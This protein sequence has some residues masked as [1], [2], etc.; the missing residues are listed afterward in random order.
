MSIDNL[1][2]QYTSGQAHARVTPL[3][4]KAFVI[5]RVVDDKA[6]VIHR[7]VDERRR[8]TNKLILECSCSN[9]RRSP[10]L[11]TLGCFWRISWTYVGATFA[12]AIYGF[13]RIVVNARRNVN[14]H[15]NSVL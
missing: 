4:D 13:E 1:A 6:F 9:I 12:K 10:A 3:G 15:A 11:D 5:H 14:D 2:E 8:S 7:G